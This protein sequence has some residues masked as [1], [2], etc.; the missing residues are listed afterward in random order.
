[1]DIEEEDLADHHADAEDDDDD[2]EACSMGDESNCGEGAG[3]VSK[4]R[5]AHAVQSFKTA[6]K[7]MNRFLGIVFTKLNAT[8]VSHFY[9][10]KLNKKLS[11]EMRQ[12]KLLEKFFPNLTE[13]E[14]EEPRDTKS[15]TYESIDKEKVD[16]LS[17]HSKR[18]NH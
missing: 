16:H 7:Q 17:Q 15:F 4:G 1:M 11:L 8:Y 6:K 5:G 18:R 9:T 10:S 14:K 2:D 3:V 12:R 13:E